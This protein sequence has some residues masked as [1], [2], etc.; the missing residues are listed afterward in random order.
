MDCFDTFLYLGRVSWSLMRMIWTG[1]ILSLS[2][3]DMLR[4]QPLTCP[5]SLL[6]FRERAFSHLVVLHLLWPCMFMTILHILQAW[7]LSVPGKGGCG[8]HRSVLRSIAVS[9]SSALCRY[10]SVLVSD[11]LSY[12]VEVHGLVLG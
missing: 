9:E 7:I 10:R 6:S 11:N 1:G 2:D 5:F 4:Q 12:R 3:V 8:L